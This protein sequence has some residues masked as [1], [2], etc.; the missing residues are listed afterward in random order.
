MSTTLHKTAEAFLAGFA[1][2]SADQHLAL[3]AENCSHIFAPSSLGISQ[4]K[5]NS[6]FAAH[7]TNL[8]LVLDGFPVTVKETHV[9]EAGRQ[10]IIWA[11]AVPKF[12]QEAKGKPEEVN[13]ADW[14]YVGEYI[15]ILDLDE[16]G[17]ITR[18]VEFLDSKNTVRLFALA[19][20]ARENL[21]VNQTREK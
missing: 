14:E 7:I 2:L 8:K 15:F 17:K 5:S 13:E 1:T 3:R 6:D 18:I 20:K 9:N 19:E 4:P 12:R 16:E 11:T 10:I 21:A